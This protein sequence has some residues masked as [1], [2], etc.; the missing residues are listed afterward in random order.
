[1]KQYKYF[2][3]LSSLFIFLVVAGCRSTTPAIKPAKVADPAP[4]S[5]QT[6]ITT[7]D[8]KTKSGTPQPKIDS[9]ETKP[10]VTKEK[11]RSIAHQLILWAPNRVLDV[12]DIVRVRLRAGFGFGLG[13]RATKYLDAYAGSYTTVYAGLP[14]PRCRRIPKSPVG[15]E[16]YN[17]AKA[18][19]I[20][21]T[22]DGGIGPGYSPT[23]F[24]G[25]FQL[26]LLGIDIGVDPFEII[27][28]AGGIIL[29]DPRKDDL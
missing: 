9:P 8:A 24:G 3:Q 6:Q 23:E 13:V 12:F 5:T 15:L 25:G 27:D 28:F 17:G 16:S 11:G 1:M 7:T 19:V 29:W 20:D 4:D 26:I 22:V 21:L 2:F 14:G 18:S 10:E